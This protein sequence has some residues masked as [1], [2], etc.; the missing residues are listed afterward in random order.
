MH[1]E[2]R[3]VPNNFTPSIMVPVLKE[4]S[5]YCANV[6]DSRPISLINTFSKV[7]EFY[8]DVKL[9]QLYRSDDALYG[10]IAK[11]GCQAAL[12]TVNAVVDHF[13]E[14]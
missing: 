2:L 11:K 9:A 3:Y 5:G 12:L 4:K 8:V 10:F 7:F 6:S 1:L 14:R 13:V